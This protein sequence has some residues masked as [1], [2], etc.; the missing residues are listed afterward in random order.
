MFAV[1]AAICDRGTAH[2]SY[3]S[4]A[5]E[6]TDFFFFIVSTENVEE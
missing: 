6:N 5:D 2:V 4:V 3:R 1:F